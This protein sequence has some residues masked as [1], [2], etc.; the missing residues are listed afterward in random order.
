LHSLSQHT[1]STQNVDA[2]S[3]GSTH[4]VARD[5]VAI[6]IPDAASHTPRNQDSD[7]DR[8]LRHREGLIIPNATSVAFLV[9]RSLQG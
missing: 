9:L 1:P 8:A 3:F 6:K 4:G 2:Q 5:G 7:A